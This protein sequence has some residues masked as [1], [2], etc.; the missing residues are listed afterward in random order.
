MNDLLKHGITQK[1]ILDKTSDWKKEYLAA[2][3]AGKTK[4][5]DAIQ[6]V[7]KAAGSTAEEADKKINKWK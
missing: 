7:Y 2:D 5:R 3:A 4:I 6:K 1:K